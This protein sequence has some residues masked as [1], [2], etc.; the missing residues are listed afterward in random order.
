MNNVAS[1]IINYLSTR[2]NNG[3]FY[4]YYRNDSEVAYIYM[5]KTYQ[6]EINLQNLIKNNKIK[7]FLDNDLQNYYLKC[8]RKYKIKHIIHE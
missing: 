6:S 3:K 7:Y 8:I 1:R 4:T 5:F 2:C